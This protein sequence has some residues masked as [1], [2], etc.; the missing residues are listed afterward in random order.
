MYLFYV[1]V[2]QQ[3][4]YVTRTRRVGVK[5]FTRLWYLA[6][7]L[8][9]KTMVSLSL[10]NQLES[11]IKMSHIYR[12]NRRGEEMCYDISKAIELQKPMNKETNSLNENPNHGCYECK[13][14]SLQS[15]FVVFYFISFHTVLGHFWVEEAKRALKCTSFAMN[16]QQFTPKI[17]LMLFFRQ[18]CH[19]YDMYN[20]STGKIK[21]NHR[22]YVTLS[23]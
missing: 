23:G 18:L 9:E 1:L 6:F 14:S 10:Y 7:G 12:K 21:R 13:I 19:S 20:I 15:V 17:C 5:I 22:C 11:A 16:I 8:K 3:V 4:F 2:T